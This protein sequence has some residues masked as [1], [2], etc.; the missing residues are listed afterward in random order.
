MSR[1]KVRYTG[2]GSEHD[3][4]MMEVTPDEADRLEATELWT[5]VKKT[6]KKKET[7]DG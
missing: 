6:T 3:K 4:R 2:P 7:S 5:R 1:V